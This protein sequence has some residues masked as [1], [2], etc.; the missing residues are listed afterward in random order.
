MIE[1]CNKLNIT[2]RIDR[3]DKLKN[4][5]QSKSSQFRI[6]RKNDIKILGEYIYQKYDNIGLER[7]YLKYKEICQQ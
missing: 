6:C 2:Y 1:L 3:I 4:G 7:K 5:K